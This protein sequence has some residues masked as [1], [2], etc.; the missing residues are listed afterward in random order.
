MLP[1]SKGTPTRNF[2]VP[3]DLYRAAR[4]AASQ[5]GENLTEHVIV[6]ALL[7]YVFEHGKDADN[8]N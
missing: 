5:R 2:R 6:P 3:D 1:V 8:A 4:E 7:A